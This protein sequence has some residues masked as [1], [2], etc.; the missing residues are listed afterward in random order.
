M[1]VGSRLQLAPETTEVAIVRWWES[2][3]TDFSKRLLESAQ[4]HHGVREVLGPT[5][6]AVNGRSGSGKTTLAGALIKEW[7]VS[8]PDLRVGVLA[9]DDLMWWEPMWQWHPLVIDGVLEA[10]RRG[11]D[12]QLVPPMWKEKG[13]SGCIRVPQDTDVLLFEGVGSSQVPFT[14]YLDT[15]VWVQSDYVVAKQRGLARDIDRDVNGGAEDAEDFWDRW[16]E[17][18]NQFLEDDMPWARADFFVEGVASEM[19]SPHTIRFQH[20]R[21]LHTLVGMGR[22]TANR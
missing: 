17:S 22:F 7:G 12:V 11:Q 16:A 21:P 19:A 18:E 15:S 8:A 9:A 13:R 10:L 2:G 1:T 20:L 3:F 14:E 5:I 4:T 6:I